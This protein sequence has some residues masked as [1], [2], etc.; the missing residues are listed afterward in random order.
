[1]PEKV[2]VD[3]NLDIIIVQSFAAVSFEQMWESISAVRRLQKETGI[4]RVLVDAGDMELMPSTSEMFMLA[5][6]FPRTMKI[7]VLISKMESL[8]ESMQFGETV[9]QNRGANIRLFESKNAALEWLEK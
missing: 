4:D 9:A 7:A 5:K 8:H 1:M 2:S 3:E 6:E